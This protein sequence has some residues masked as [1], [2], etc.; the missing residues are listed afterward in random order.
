MITILN[1]L[2]SER[3][4][5]QDDPYLPG[6]QIGRLLAAAV[7]SKNFCDLLL[8]DAGQAISAGFQG[9]EFCLTKSELDLIL[10]IRASS[11]QDFARQLGRSRTLSPEVPQL[12]ELVPCDPVKIEMFVDVSQNSGMD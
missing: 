4:Q 2:F 3:P 11:L 9:E 1:P 10:S 12:Q 6:R 7:V 8:R 5:D